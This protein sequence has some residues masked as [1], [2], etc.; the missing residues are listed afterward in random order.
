MIRSTLTHY[1]A[2]FGYVADGMD[3]PCSPKALTA[4]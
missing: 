3:L 4:R 1:D 2:E